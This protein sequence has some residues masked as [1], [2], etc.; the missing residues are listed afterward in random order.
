MQ[1]ALEENYVAN[2]THSLKAP[3]ASV[4]ALTEALV[5]AVPCDAEKQQPYFGMILKE[6]NAQSHMV[7]EIL[8]LSR[9][10]SGRIEFQKTYFSAD[11]CFSDLFEKYATYCEFSQI[12]FSVQDSIH[13]LPELF[14]DRQYI[15]QLMGILLENAVKYVYE[16]GAGIEVSAAI[17]HGKAVFC[18]YDDGSAIPAKDLPNVFH[19]F[20]TGE[21][22]ADKNSSGMGLAIAKAITDSLKE[23]IWIE[24]SEKKG[25]SIYFTVSVHS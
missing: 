8:D 3:I 11:E 15:N 6:V 13:N 25:T 14:S 23:R 5:D 2:V 4:K 24:S 10:Q 1:E 21:N 17:D 22:A 9:L 18:V 12:P 16:S 19:T 7:Q 20:Y